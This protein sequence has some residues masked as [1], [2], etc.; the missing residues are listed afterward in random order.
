MSAVHTHTRD[1][2]VHVEADE[3]GQTFTL[4]QLFTEWDVRLTADQ[5]GSLM[6]EDGSELKVYVNGTEQPGEPAMLRLADEQ[7]VTLVY[8]DHQV[9]I[10]DSYDF[11]GV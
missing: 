10:P 4:G 9:D 7:Q 1:G 2:I 3:E 6:A 5:V 8:G 11:S